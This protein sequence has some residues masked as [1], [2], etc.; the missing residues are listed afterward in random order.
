M[1]FHES[2]SLIV[3]DCPNIIKLFRENGERTFERKHSEFIRAIFGVKNL[4]I[5]VL[6]LYF[7]RK[8]TVE[9]KNEAL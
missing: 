1:Q 2:S 6:E 7:L 8:K 9:W 5:Q 4:S 3:G